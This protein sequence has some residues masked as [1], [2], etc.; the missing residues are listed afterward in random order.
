MGGVTGAFGYPHEAMTTVALLGVPW[1]LLEER[2]ASRLVQVSAGAGPA[3][4]RRLGAADAQLMRMS[5]P[6]SRHLSRRLSARSRYWVGIP[7]RTLGV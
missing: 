1:D 6:R 5:S 2:L 4:P 7:L 3:P